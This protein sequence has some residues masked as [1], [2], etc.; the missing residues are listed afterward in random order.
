MI[1]AKG[2]HAHICGVGFCAK[3]RNKGKKGYMIKRGEEKIGD[4]LK[5]VSN[6]SNF[7]EALGTF[8]AIQ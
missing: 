6:F 5:T 2:V 3:S 4:H 8:L 1:G 7:S